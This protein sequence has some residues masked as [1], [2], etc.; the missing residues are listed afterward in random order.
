MLENTIQ[1]VR[2]KKPRSSMD[3][4]AAIKVAMFIRRIKARKCDKIYRRLTRFKTYQKI[5]PK[6]H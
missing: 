1:E 5:F 2:L 4:T 6:V 3:T